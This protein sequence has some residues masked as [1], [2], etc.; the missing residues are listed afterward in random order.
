MS[1]LL[2][3]RIYHYDF[4]LNKRR[5]QGTTQTF[6]REE[7]AL[8]EQEA[9]DAARIGRELPHQDKGR[10]RQKQSF[11]VFYFQHHLRVRKQRGTPQCCERCGTEDPSKRYDWANLSGKYEDINDYAR[12]CRLCHRKY[13]QSRRTAHA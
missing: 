7:A 10:G 12:L 4:Y 11:P 2:R 1:L 5:Y 8:I 13:D 3:G 6:D 9:K